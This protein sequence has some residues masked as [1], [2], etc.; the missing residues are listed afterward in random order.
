[1]DF[2][3]WYPIV[4]SNEAE[5]ERKRKRCDQE[6]N[7]PLVLQPFTKS[8]TVVD[9]VSLEVTVVESVEFRKAHCVARLCGC[10]N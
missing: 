9:G 2:L 8:R 5:G 1:M 10:P 4:D 3:E 7:S 6:G